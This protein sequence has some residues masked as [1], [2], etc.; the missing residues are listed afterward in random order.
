LNPSGHVVFQ[1]GR[2]DVHIVIVDGRIV[3]YAHQLQVSD[4]LATT[5]RAE[6]ETIEYLRSR[7]GA[8]DWVKGMDPDQPDFELHV[9]PYK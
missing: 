7:M 1:A 6:S 2:D 8:A 9:N 4:Q 5:Q 3:K